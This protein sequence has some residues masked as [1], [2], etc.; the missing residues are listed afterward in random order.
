MFNIEAFYHITRF[1]VSVILESHFCAFQFWIHIRDF[2]KNPQTRYH[3]A[4][5]L[6]TS[7]S[8][9]I[10]VVIGTLFLPCGCQTSI[11]SSR[12]LGNLGDWRFQY[13]DRIDLA[14]FNFIVESKNHALLIVAKKRLLLVSEWSGGDIGFFP[15]PPPPPLPPSISLSLRPP[16]LL[17]TLTK[18]LPWRLPPLPW[19]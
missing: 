8:L 14:W 7:T 16:L 5:S 17:L 3:R 13:I 10:R 11:L 18:R 19:K 15:L 2:F 9:A 6:C 1:L 12:N 4:T